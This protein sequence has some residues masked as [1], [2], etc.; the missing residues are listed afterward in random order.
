MDKKFLDRENFISYI[1]EKDKLF[2]RE[3]NYFSV[4]WEECL[5]S[6]YWKD[7]KEKIRI[8]SSEEVNFFMDKVLELRSRILWT[9]RSYRKDKWNDDYTRKLVET[10]ERELEKMS[11][12]EF[13][14]NK[15]KDGVRRLTNKE[16]SDMLET[17]KTWT[18]DQLISEINRLKTENEQLKNNQTLTSSE[19]Q[20]K[21][22]QNQ[23]K[24][25][26]LESNV[27]NSSSSDIPN[28]NNNLGTISLIT[29]I[30]ALASLGI[31]GVVKKTKKVK[32]SR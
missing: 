6:D 4:V 12:E 23:K 16:I 26:K 19:R 31:Y 17:F 18:K 1:D 24:L 20:E 11:E 10:N 5:T 3:K 15:P 25:E 30:L 2:E 28:S 32:K 14:S 9:I 29:A 8:L 22:R 21:L 13:Y 7:W 27:L